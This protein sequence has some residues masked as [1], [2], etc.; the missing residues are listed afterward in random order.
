MPHPRARSTASWSGQQQTQLDERRVSTAPP[1]TCTSQAFLSTSCVSLSNDFSP[2]SC[3]EYLINNVPTKQFLI[4]QRQPSPFSIPPP[5]KKKSCTIALSTSG[6]IKVEITTKALPWRGEHGT[7]PFRCP[8]L[9]WHTLFRCDSECRQDA[10]VERFCSWSF[11]HQVQTRPKASP[12]AY[13]SFVL[14]DSFQMNS[15]TLLLTSTHLVLLLHLPL[16]YLHWV[17]DISGHCM[18]SQLHTVFRVPTNW[19]NAPCGITTVCHMW[20]VI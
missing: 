20:P 17:L 16:F 2:L 18:R 3:Y 13:D 11:Q 8:R 4:Q 7:R 9:P 5:K 1:L 10:P 12:L 14:D 15:L 6:I 19:C